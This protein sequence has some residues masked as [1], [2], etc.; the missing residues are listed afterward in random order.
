MDL[1]DRPVLIT[2][3]DFTGKVGTVT[4]ILFGLYVLEMGDLKTAKREDEIELLFTPHEIASIRT[5]EVD[6]QGNQVEP[7]LNELV[8]PFGISAEDLADF[9]ASFYDEATQ[10]ITGTGA[11]Q[12]GQDTYQKF[13]GKTLAEILTDIQEEALDFGNYAAMLFILVERLKRAV[14]TIEGEDDDD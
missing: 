7:A 4:E 9:T 5:V 2:S 6:D 8:K 3:G 11:V 14:T 1:L 12:Y 10:R 13:E